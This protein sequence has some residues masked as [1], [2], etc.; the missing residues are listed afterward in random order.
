MT[1]LVLTLLSPLQ[2]STRILLLTKRHVILTDA[3]KSQAQIVIGLKDVAGVSVTSLQDGL[4]SLHLSEVSELSR[5][6][7][8]SGSP[9]AEVNWIC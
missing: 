4:F 5:W 6:G 3:K 1:R 9:G 2:T 7:L 8:W